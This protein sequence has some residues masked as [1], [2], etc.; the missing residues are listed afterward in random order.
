M[1]G[2]CRGDVLPAG[3]V[4]L[5]GFG[6][7]S[8]TRLP[9]RALLVPRHTDVFFTSSLVVIEVTLMVLTLPF[10]LLHE[11][12]HVLAGRRLGLRSRVRLSNRFYFLVF[13]TV[14]DGLVSVPRGKGIC[15]CWRGFSRIP[16]RW[17]PSSAAP[18]CYA[19]RRLTSRERRHCRTC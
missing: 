15:R 8:G 17:L 11:V 12:F 10:T 13:E 18:G 4:V 19:G 16:F 14:M 1:A 5:C 7:S 3:L 9:G 6:G 2:A